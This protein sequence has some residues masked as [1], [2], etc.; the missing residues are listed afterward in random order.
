MVKGEEKTRLLFEQDP[1]GCGDEL[2]EKRL[3]RDPFANGAIDAD[4]C[5]ALAPAFDPCMR[6]EVSTLLGPGSLPWWD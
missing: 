4:R 2:L 1:Y 5:P 6:D 3:A